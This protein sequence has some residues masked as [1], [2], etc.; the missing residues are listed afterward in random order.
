MSKN[1][2]VDSNKE[3]SFIPY[4]H[5]TV[6]ENDLAA[7]CSV[8][9]SDW[10]TQGPQISSFEQAL[11]DKFGAQYATVVSS[12]T[13]AL[14]LVGLALGFPVD[15]NK[16]K[17]F[18]PYDIKQEKRDVI[19]TTPLTFLASVNCILYTG[20]IPEFIDIDPNYYTIDPS[21]LETKIKQLRA[22]KK[23]LKA[24]IA[25]DYAGHPCDWEALQKIADR[26][27]L[28]LVEDASHALGATYKERPIGSCNYANVTVFSFHPVKQITTGEGGAVLTNDKV[29]DE[30]LK[31]LRSHGVTKDSNLLKKNEGPWYYEMQELGFNYRITDFQC[32]LGEN[33]LKRLE[34]FIER[35]KNIATYYN[36]RFSKLNDKVIP[37]KVSPYVSHAWHIYPLQI[38]FELMNLDKGNFFRNLK[39]KYIGVQV[40]YIP[41][42]L[43]PY[44][45]RQFAFR[46]GDFP[47]SEAFYLKEISLPIYPS[48][49]PKEMEY[50]ADCVLE[51]LDSGI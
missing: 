3:K 2:P 28:K 34:D 13:A 21:Q 20:A 42:H 40:H 17:S 5:Q 12:A 32:A 25:I 8:L 1:F 50:V 10:L 49:K 29:L 24:I 9:R 22:Q 19:L 4:G 51:L 33:Q 41:V 27:E 44:Y 16:E 35:R 36:Q 45:Q 11:C 47:I 14:H 46:K 18:I 38:D 15:S 48:L 7:V 43:Q 39:D 37:P 23:R 31:L 26:Y 30:R 6:T